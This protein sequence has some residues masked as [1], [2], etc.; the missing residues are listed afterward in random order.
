LETAD[1]DLNNN[2]WPAK[3]HPS[4][5]ELFK[6]KDYKWDSDAKENPMQRA[7]RSEKLEKNETPDK[8]IKVNEE[9]EK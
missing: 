1:V 9:E 2:S 3:V 8:V 4:K 5:F 7:K 6:R